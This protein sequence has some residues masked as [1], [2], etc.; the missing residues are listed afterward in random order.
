MVGVGCGVVNMNIGMYDRPSFCSDR[1]CASWNL[2][3]GKFIGGVV[4]GV[5]L[6]IDCSSIIWVRHCPTCSSVSSLN[7]FCSSAICSL[8]ILSR[9]SFIDS[10]AC[11]MASGVIGWAFVYMQVDSIRFLNCVG[12]F[13][14]IGL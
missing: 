6:G 13:S 2:K 10:I 14:C 1:N 7:C 11:L 5:V 9:S 8:V 4:S 3:L 12:L